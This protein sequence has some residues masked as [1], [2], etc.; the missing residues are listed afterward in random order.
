M[1]M[2]VGVSSGYNDDANNG[3]ASIS[4]VVYLATRETDI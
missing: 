4:L 3:S 2:V 1:M